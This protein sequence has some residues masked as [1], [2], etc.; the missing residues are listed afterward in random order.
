[1]SK[2]QVSN[3]TLHDKGYNKGYDTGYDDN[4]LHDILQDKL[5]DDIYS[6]SVSHKNIGSKDVT[7]E[8]NFNIYGI[9]CVIIVLLIVLFIY[10]SNTDSHNISSVI[11]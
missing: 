10:N 8:C 5:H 11:I 2:I 4:I 7:E 1:M 6:P 9:I 3:D